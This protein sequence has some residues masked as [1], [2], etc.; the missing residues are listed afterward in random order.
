MAERGCRDEMVLA[1]KFTANYRAFEKKTEDQSQSDMQISNFGGNGSKSLRHSLE[2]S[3]KKL[4]TNY[5]DIMYL[6]CKLSLF[7]SSSF[8]LENFTSPQ[9][10]G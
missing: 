10:F 4:R 5:V 8:S 7:L 3:L 9:I 1:T 6:H 2:A